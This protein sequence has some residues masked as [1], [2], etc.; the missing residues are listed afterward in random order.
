MSATTSTTPS[1]PP[2]AL[3]LHGQIYGRLTVERL[4]PLRPGRQG[5][6]W[7]CRCACGAEVVSE[8]RRL[9]HGDLRQCK[10]CAYKVSN[11]PKVWTEARAAK[12]AELWSRDLTDEEI[13]RAVSRVDPSKRTITVSAMLKYAATIGLR[14]RRA[15][16]VKPEVERKVARLPSVMPPEPPPVSVEIEF[17]S[18]KR[19]RAESAALERV[20]K[21]KSLR[22]IEN[23]TIDKIAEASGLRQA[24]RG[25]DA[26]DV[27]RGVV[28]KLIGIVRTARWDALEARAQ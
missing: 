27:A 15:V 23:E 3:N 16:P 2:G 26:L 28:R 22:D 1:L 12:L 10:A 4:M 14:S 21:L 18:S 7:L 13:A 5:V 17:D 6:E 19:G 25:H 11:G 9:R 20:C 24:F 8:T